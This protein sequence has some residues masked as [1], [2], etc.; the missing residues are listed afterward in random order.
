MSFN[1]EVGVVDLIAS[2]GQTEFSFL[3]AVYNL[4]DVVVY[5]YPSGQT[6]YGSALVIDVDY[7]V[8]IDGEN[9]G[10]VTFTSAAELNDN[11]RIERQLPAIDTIEIQRNGDLSSTTLNYVRNYTQY[12]MAD[13]VRRNV[14]TK[15]Y[16]KSYTDSVVDFV[17]GVDLSL[18][19]NKTELLSGALDGRYYT[20]SEIDTNQ[21]TK[22]ELDGG[23]LDTR[24]PVPEVIE[25][26]C[27]TAVSE[28]SSG[29]IVVTKV[30]RQ[31]TIEWSNLVSGSSQS[32]RGFTLDTDLGLSADYEAIDDF[33]DSFIFY[34]VSPNMYYLE[35][36]YSDNTQ[37]INFT[38]RILNASS[39]TI[40]LS[41]T[42]SWP[43][44][45]LS[46]VSKG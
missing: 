32:T 41:P 17:S 1:T 4:T 33:Y 22:T 14:E 25:I 2:A 16:S 3:F 24:Y 9:G 7:S 29:T 44:G 20:E 23:A 27:A 38:R 43:N 37:K 6:E 39:G 21:Y 45:T 18:F 15:D 36:L 19:Y 28:F 31:V 30:G 10:I 35:I 13:A 40:T 46:Y 34:S 11:I 26:D 12:Q 5:Q 8:T 42:I